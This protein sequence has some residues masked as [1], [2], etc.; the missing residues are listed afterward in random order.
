MAA[1][2]IA[3]IARL[4]KATDAQS[5]KWAAAA[6]LATKADAYKG[7]NFETA[8]AELESISAQARDAK[9]AAAQCTDGSAECKHLDTV[10]SNLAAAVKAQTTYNADAANFHH[11][12]NATIAIIIICVS[13]VVCIS[14]G[15]IW[16]H[17]DKKKAAAKEAEHAKVEAEA[18][19]APAMDAAMDAAV[20]FN[21][22]NYTAMVDA[23]M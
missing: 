10:S 9:W 8:K 4:T 18:E 7:K 11:S 20:N 2:D 3:A 5:T 17:V 23:E 1:D 16:R 21:D 12:S 14:G 19:G 22:D 13:A 15:C 6:K